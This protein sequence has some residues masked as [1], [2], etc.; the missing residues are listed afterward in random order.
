M[1]TKP[2]DAG[3]ATSAPV[4][5]AKEANQLSHPAL[6]EGPGN[7]NAGLQRDER[8]AVERRRAR[9]GGAEDSGAEGRNSEIRQRQE[10]EGEA[11]GKTGILAAQ[12]V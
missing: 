8:P 10:D 2:T 11:G 7:G 5:P 9:N 3:A 1:W 6:K 4:P 12:E